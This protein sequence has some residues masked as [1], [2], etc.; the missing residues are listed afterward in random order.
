MDNS[1]PRSICTFCL[2]SAFLRLIRLSFSP[3]SPSALHYY[4]SSMSCDLSRRSFR[5]RKLPCAFGCTYG[6]GTVSST[7]SACWSLSLPFRFDT[8]T[9]LRPGCCTSSVIS[10]NDAAYLPGL[11]AAR[12]SAFVE[13]GGVGPPAH[14][15]HFGESPPLWS[16]AVAIISAMCEALNHPLIPILPVCANYSGF[17][18][19]NMSILIVLFVL[20]NQRTSRRAGNK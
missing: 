10:T 15:K 5:I 12:P 2:N 8:R 11:H 14:P 18:L 4:L 7:P 20:E 3:T 9:G 6:L 17:Y 13:G 16:D 19:P 1:E